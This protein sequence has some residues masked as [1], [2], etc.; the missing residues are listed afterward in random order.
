MFWKWKWVS[1]PLQ[2]HRHHLGRLIP[3]GVA[4]GIAVL[5]QHLFLSAAVWKVLKKR[6]RCNYGELTASDIK[7]YTR[8]RFGR[9]RRWKLPRPCQP[10]RS[11]QYGRKARKSALTMENV[12]SLSPAGLALTHPNGCRELSSARSGKRFPPPHPRVVV[13]LH[14]RQQHLSFSERR[15]ALLRRTS[16]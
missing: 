1:R 16:I 13:F 10:A 6:D 14:S 9:G 15:W 4:A 8:R 5:K 3:P 11:C 12:E 7:R 2:W